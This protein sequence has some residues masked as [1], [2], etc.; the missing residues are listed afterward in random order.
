MYDISC[1]TGMILRYYGLLVPAAPSFRL[2]GLGALC[3]HTVHTVS[4]ANHNLSY[5]QHLYGNLPV[6]RR[7]DLVTS[8]HSAFP[9]CYSAS[10]CMHIL[11]RSTFPCL[12]RRH[13]HPHPQLLPQLHYARFSRRNWMRSRRLVLLSR[14]GN[15]TT[16]NG[17]S[18]RISR[19][20]SASNCI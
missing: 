16:A 15:E 19:E 5:L 14:I 7:P 9:D 13:Y 1:T 2:R 4:I 6:V 3:I 10:F 20:P 17:R 18:W 8:V 12:F 11:F